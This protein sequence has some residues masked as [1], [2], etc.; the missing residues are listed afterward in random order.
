L[1][2]C[3]RPPIR[4]PAATPAFPRQ[5]RSPLRQAGSLLAAPWRCR[6]WSRDPWSGNFV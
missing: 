3:A 5:I 2:G 1:H 4:H 6:Q